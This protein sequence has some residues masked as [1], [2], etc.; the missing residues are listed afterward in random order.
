MSQL[1]AIGTVTGEPDPAAPPCYGAE[2]KKDRN[3]AG[4]R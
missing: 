3:L 1:P 4:P 2:G